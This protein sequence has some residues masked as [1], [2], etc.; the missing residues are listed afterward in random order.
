M[1]S[2]RASVMTQ[3]QA[4]ARRLGA[5]PEDPASTPIVQQLVRCARLSPDAEHTL[6]WAL[7]TLHAHASA[8]SDEVACELLR[9]ARA[10]LERSATGASTTSPAADPALAWL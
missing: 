3:A 2:V 4:A 7:A 9:A 8:A 6:D 5:V 10:R 1:A